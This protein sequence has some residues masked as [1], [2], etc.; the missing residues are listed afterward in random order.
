VDTLNLSVNHLGDAGA[1]ALAAAPPGA[2]RRLFLRDNQVGDTG[3]EALAR[4][5]HVWRLADLDL[6]ENQIGDSGAKALAEAPWT[7]LEYLNLRENAVGTAGAR[8]LLA[9]AR[10]PGPPH[11]YLGSHR[12]RRT[13]KADLRKAFGDRVALD[14]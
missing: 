8:A 13:V 9:L 3:A 14:P 2:L 5:P 10:L 6:A 12:L 4:A 7:R 11:L 1:R